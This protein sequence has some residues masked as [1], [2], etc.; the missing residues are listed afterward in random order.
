MKRRLTT[1]FMCI[2]L[3]LSGLDAAGQGKMYTRKVLLEDFPAKTMKVVSEGSSMTESALR[4]EVA[5]HWRISPY[6]FCSRSE[7]GKLSSD[8]SYYFLTMV[9]EGGVAFL[10][11]SKGGKEDETDNSKKP[12]EV[13]RIPFANAVAP[14]GVELASMGALIDVLQTFVEEATVS[15]HVAYGGLDAICAKSLSGKTVYTGDDAGDHLTAAQEGAVVGI[16][17]CPPEPEQK[18]KAACYKMLIAADT[19]ELFYYSKSR[20]RSEEDGTFSQAELKSFERR[21]GTIAR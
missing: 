3:I 15:D 13:V 18:Q 7:Y 1:Y 19:H 17:V 11:I 6:E 5:A 2:V 14:S 9:Q 8:N 21:N 20:Y 4:S 10:M 12:F 16:S